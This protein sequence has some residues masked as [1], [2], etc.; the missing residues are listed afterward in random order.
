MPSHVDALI[1]V[2]LSIL[3]DSNFRITTWFSHEICG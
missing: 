2:H 3:N 1:E